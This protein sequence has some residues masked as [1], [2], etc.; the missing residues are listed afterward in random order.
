MGSAV[1]KIIRKTSSE[2]QA[3]VERPEE[4][5]QQKTPAQSPRA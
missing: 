3:P 1:L 4:A 5:R 2:K